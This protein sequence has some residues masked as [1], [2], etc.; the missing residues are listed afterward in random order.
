MTRQDGDLYSA[1]SHFSRQTATVTDQKRVKTRTLYDP[2]C[3]S[4][5]LKW[6]PM[7]TFDKIPFPLTLWCL[8]GYDYYFW[9]TTRT[10]ERGGEREREKERGMGRFLAL[11]LLWVLLP[12]KR[13]DETSS[14][15]P[16]PLAACPN[17]AN[18]TSCLLQRWKTLVQTKGEKEE[19]AILCV[20]VHMKPPAGIM[21]TY[22][23]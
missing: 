13:R 1:I 2:V 16:P 17:R 14:S 12:G 4:R 15:S 22:A 18:S 5:N 9:V 19:I 6:D 7:P 23:F 3:K 20:L 8:C 11:F 21:R 10:E